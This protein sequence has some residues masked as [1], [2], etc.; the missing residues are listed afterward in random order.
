MNVPEIVV[1]E[2]IFY[3][4]RSLRFEMGCSHTTCS[5][6]K[7]LCRLLNQM[8]YLECLDTPEVEFL[9]GC[10][11]LPPIK[12]LIRK[13]CHAKLVNL[14][15]KRLPYLTTLLLNHLSTYPNEMSEVVGPL[16]INLPLFESISFP[17]GGGWCGNDRTP[18]RKYIQE[19]L[20]LIQ[21]MNNSLSNIQLNWKNTH[22]KKVVK[23]MIFMRNLMRSRFKW[24]DF[25][26][27]V[28]D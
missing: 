10:P 19:A 15:V 7:V 4:V 12:R 27:L 28:I 11:S 5:C 6:R 9:S 3:H 1:D 2:E 13:D 18:Y 24:H 17:S 16:F 22:V 21:N 20:Q 14:L 8:P 23:I 25:H 26:S